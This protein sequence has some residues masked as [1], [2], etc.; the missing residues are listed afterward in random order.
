MN[1]RFAN[2][3][4]GAFLLSDARTGRVGDTAQIARAG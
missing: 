2:G 3:A 4:L 1:L